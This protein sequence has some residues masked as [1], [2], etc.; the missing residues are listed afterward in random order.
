MNSATVEFAVAAE[1]R[2]GGRRLLPWIWA[3][4]FVL[5]CVTYVGYH[6]LHDPKIEFLRSAWAGEWIVHPHPDIWVV[7]TPTCRD[8]RFVHT[9][10]L[11]SV[12][13]SCPIE[14]TALRGF[15]L[16]V[17]GRSFDVA[18]S[19]SWKQAVEVDLA[20]CLQVG[21]NRVA[22]LV[23]APEGPPALLVE[24]PESIRSGPGWRV[25]DE[26][27]PRQGIEVDAVPALRGETVL[28]GKANPLRR[29]SGFGLYCGALLCYL[30]FIAYAMVPRDWKPW[31][32]SVSVTRPDD[33]EDSRGW[34][35]R[36]GLCVGILAVVT[37][38]QFR[39]TQVYPVDRSPFDL[40]G[41][42]EYI[43][44]VARH[45]DAPTADQGGVMFQP[46][47]YYWTAAAVLRLTGVVGDATRA[48]LKRVQL[49]STTIAIL[50]LIA[51]W[52]LLC[53][54]FPASSAARVLGLAT[55]AMFPV[56]FYMDSM[57]TNEVFAGAV[58][59]MAT[60]LACRWGPFRSQSAWWLAGPVGVV[61]GLGLLSKYTGLFLCVS[62]AAVYGFRVMG[63]PGD[64]RRW[65][66]IGLFM[67][68]VAA[69]AAWLYVRNALLF[70]DPFVGNWD[71]SSGF[72]YE[73]APGYRT[74]GYYARFGEVLFGT[75]YR[76]LFTSFWDGNY[77]S[78]WGD[79][80]GAF[81][82]TDSQADDMVA[83]LIYWLALLPTAAIGFG[84]VRAVRHVL[85]V[86]WCH[87]YLV[88]VLTTLFT[89][90]GV[91]FFTMEVP[92]YSTVKAFFFLSLLPAAA[93][94]A[95]LGLEAMRINLGRLRW[96][97]DANLISLALLVVGSYWY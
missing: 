70:G 54:L 95:A 3:C 8:V 34:L 55:V 29:S 28:Q 5:A 6:A 25:A 93:V 17:N 27:G 4:S 33:G 53:Q 19:E 14:I 43:H 38:V 12:P 97:A 35:Y 66:G 96:L 11:A 56:G 58:I 72:H 31:L 49:L 52:R 24:G 80:H 61:C 79:P 81:F 20:P 7:D 16:E 73:Q 89:V 63:R 74:A 42:V 44:H 90:T 59:A 9:V 78:L 15:E 88:L 71:A 77:A 1:R 18:V 26:S 69:L 83:A 46:P 22:I 67:V 76:A 23:H 87:P 32:R 30:C 45:W 62:T 94:Y 86:Q 57:I 75:P 40:G 36:H 91:M 48:E 50:C 41:H 10:E 92:T 64:W 68:V 84:F 82:S 47:L 51:V 65:A 60:W 2:W 21:E 37:L 13:E 39:N 85:V